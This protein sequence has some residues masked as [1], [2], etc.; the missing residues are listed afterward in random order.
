MRDGI[1]ERHLFTVD[2]RRE[3][4]GV[5]HLCQGR[6]NRQI[7][8]QLAARASRT[9]PRASP[10]AHNCLSPQLFV[11]GIE[12]FR[13]CTIVKA[14]EITPWLSR[15]RPRATR[16][17]GQASFNVARVTRH[18][19]QGTSAYFRGS[20][21]LKKSVRPTSLRTSLSRTLTFTEAFHERIRLSLPR[22]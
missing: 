7:H 16:L 14:D 20:S 4:Y 5:N 19:A 3:R 6:A 11:R 13:V 18:A 21:G 10:L 8:G 22:R 17:V 15:T 12:S 1:G 2:S 9:E